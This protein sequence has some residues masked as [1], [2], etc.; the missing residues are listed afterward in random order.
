MGKNGSWLVT[1]GALALP[2]DRTGAF[3]GAI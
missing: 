1:A 2:L 3:I